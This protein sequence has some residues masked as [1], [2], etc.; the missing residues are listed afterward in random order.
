MTVADPVIVR[1]IAELHPTGQDHGAMTGWR[2]PPVGSE[3]RKVSLTRRARLH[4]SESAAQTQQSADGEHCTD[5]GGCGER[6]GPGGSCAAPSFKSRITE[7]PG[8]ARTC[9]GAASY[10]ADGSQASS[11]T[12]APDS[13]HKEKERAQCVTQMDH[14]SCPHVTSVTA[15]WCADAPTLLWAATGTVRQRCRCS[16][17]KQRPWHA[18]C[19]F[20][21]G[22]EIQG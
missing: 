20:A 4:R 12:C 2:S 11:T 21:P 18:S 9:C 7:R 10:D 13:I 6:G 22:V 8:R 15:L 3:V 14:L 17:I 5:G 16:W 19:A 1:H